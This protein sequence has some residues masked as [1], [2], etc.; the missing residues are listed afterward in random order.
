ML[1]MKNY[2]REYIDGCRSRVDSDLVA[3]RNLVAADKTHLDSDFEPVFFNTMVLLLDHFFVH[4]LRTIEG[5]NGNPLNEVRVM[6]ESILNH[7]NRMTADKS[8]KL[9]PANSVL[10]VKFGDEIKLTGAD[11]LLIYKAFFA[12]IES[13][14]L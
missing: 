1:G 13:K 2:T 12:E 7:N 8:I 14:Y 9:S 11:F 4:R 5:K 6:C 10:K 3:Y